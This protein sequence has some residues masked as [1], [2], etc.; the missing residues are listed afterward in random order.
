MNLASISENQDVE[1]RIAIT[2]EIAKKYISLGFNL[3][4]QKNYGVHLGFDDEDN[5]K[6]KEK[7]YFRTANGMLDSQLRGLGIG[8]AALS[9]VKNFLLD[10][11]ERSGRKR[12]EY[13]D[14]MWKLLQFSPP[15]NSKISKLRQAAFVFDNKKSREEIFSKG[16]SL[17]N[18][19]FE[20]TG[21]IISASTNLP[22]DRVIRK[23]DNLSTPVRQDVETWQ[24]I[25]LA[26]GYSKWDVGLIDSQAKKPKTKTSGLKKKKVVKKKKVTKKKIV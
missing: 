12:P 10:I 1:K 11:Y 2:P 14:S 20:A 19:A 22:V 21:Q 17:D 5:D 26:L 24:A 18:P 25:S 16:F 7:R 4:L 8:G 13:V 23:L 3:L 15:I 9:V 6:E